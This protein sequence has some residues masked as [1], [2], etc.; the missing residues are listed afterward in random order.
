MRREEGCCAYKIALSARDEWYSHQAVHLD[1][2]ISSL[3]L[4]IRITCTSVEGHWGGLNQLTRHSPGPADTEPVTILKARDSFVRIRF[5]AI[6]RLI[7]DK[8]CRQ[9]CWVQ[10]L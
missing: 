5:T 6:P 7:E 3:T 2:I 8:K 10:G 4:S 1:L 9:F